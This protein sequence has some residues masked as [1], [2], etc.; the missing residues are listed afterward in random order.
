MNNWRNYDFI[1]S[2]WLEELGDCHERAIMIKRNFSQ[3]L[4]D[5]KSELKDQKVCYLVIS[6]GMMVWQMGNMMQ[7]LEEN[8]DKYELP[9][10]INLGD[11]DLEKQKAL[12]KDCGHLDWTED[13]KYL[14]FNGFAVKYNKEEEKFEDYR[15]LDTKQNGVYF[16]FY[17]NH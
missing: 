17:E 1:K 13:C 14:C 8:P 3:R 12:S 5:L 2:R 9:S 16:E 6:H 4:S 7:A 15:T 11:Q 10:P